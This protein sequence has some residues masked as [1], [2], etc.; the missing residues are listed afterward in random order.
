MRLQN[1]NSNYNTNRWVLRRDLNESVVE[2][3]WI[4]GG[5]LFQRVGAIHAKARSPYRVLVRGPCVN[6]IEDDERRGLAAEEDRS[7]IRSW[8][9]WGARLC[10]VLYTR[11]RILNII[12]EL[13]G[14]QCN[15]RRIGDMW[16]CF[17]VRVII[18]AAVFW[19]RW[20]G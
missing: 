2:A 20:S 13:T 16:S 10:V 8:R 19:I 6:C 5:S 1:T 17:L 11:S 18:L 4:W 14:S 12:R 9:Y 15:E 7:E 3:F